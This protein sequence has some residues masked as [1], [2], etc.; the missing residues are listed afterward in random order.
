MW[1]RGLAAVAVLLGV[2]AL[3]ARAEGLGVGDKAPKLEVKEFVKGDAVDKFDKGKVYVVEF[4]A[5]WCGPCRATIPHLT[6]LQKR[7]KDV[8]FVGVSVWENDQAKVKPFV[9]EMGDKMDYRVALDSVPAGKPRGEGA[10]SQSWMTAAGQDG[11]PT[12]FI[13][14]GDGRVA[15]IGHPMQMDGPLAK[16]VEGKWDLQAAATEFKEKQSQKRK[17]NELRQKLAKAGQSGDPKDMLKVL[18]EAFA[19]DPKLEPR[20]GFQKFRLLAG[21]GGDADK[22][23]E[24]GNKLVETTL[25]DDA[26]GLNALAWTI[27]DPAA[28]GKPDPKLAQVALSAARRADELAKGKDAAIA[29]TLARAYFVSGDAAK[30]LE[31]QERAAKRAAG[32]PFEKEIKNRLEEYQKAVKKE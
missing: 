13:I 29:D 8:T 3:A 11:I 12:A 25:K 4:W 10:M 15:W 7:H 31:T 14:N 6:E 5:T 27:V 20:L 21:K 26:Q 9:K 28:K 24:Y 22:A 23:V 18:D 1:Q 16:V 17:L 32:T 30:A 19:E 2:A